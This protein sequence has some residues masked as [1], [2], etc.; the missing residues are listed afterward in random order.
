MLL[1][2][3]QLNQHP[4]LV[5]SRGFSSAAAEHWLLLAGTLGSLEHIK[6]LVYSSVSLPTDQELVLTD[7]LRYF[8]IH[9]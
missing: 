9:K 2:G 6:F 7:L 8:E 1:H 5:P 4:E 3:F